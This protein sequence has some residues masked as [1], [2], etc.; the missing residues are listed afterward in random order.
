MA[1]FKKNVG[2][3]R[4][5]DLI[6]SPAK[7]I[8]VASGSRCFAK[9]TLVQ[10]IS[11]HK[12]INEI[13]I[14]ELVLSTNNLT[15]EFE[16]KKVLET[17][18]NGTD[19]TKHMLI[20]VLN[21]GVQ[22]EC[23]KEHELR[24]KNNFIPASTIAERAMENGEWNKRK[25]SSKQFGKTE[26]YELEVFRKT[27]SDEARS[28]RKRIFENYDSEGGREIPYDKDASNSCINLDRQSNEQGRGKSHQQRSKGQQS[29]E[30]RMGYSSGK[31]ETHD[32]SRKT[33]IQQWIKEWNVNNDRGTSI[34]NKGRIQQGERVDDQ[35]MVGAF[36]S[37]VFCS[38]RP[39]IR[40]NLEAREINLDEI[41]EI[42]FYIA[43]VETFDLC[44]EDNH[45]YTVTEENIIVHNSG[46]TFII[47]YAI[48]FIATK[49]PGSRHLIARKHFN[50]VK[51]SI[52]LDTLPK[53][54]DICFPEL[55]PFIKWNNTDFYIEL[56]N[57][58]QLWFAG[59]DDKE[60]VDKILGR[61]YMTIFFNECS[62]ITYDTYNTVKSR[63]AQQCSYVNEK[64]DL[65]MGKNMCL[66]D[67]NPTTSRH[68]TK[69]LFLDK[70]DPMSE[71][72]PKQPVRNPDRYAFTYIHPHENQENISKDYIEM[73][74]SLPP[75]QRKRFLDGI[76]ADS[77]AFAL[78]D[79]DIINKHRVTVAPPLKR[80]VVSV[81]P[82]VTSHDESDE[83]GI[84]V[85]G[86]G[87]DN[88]LYPLDDRTGK[89]TPNEWA[90]AAVRAYDDWNADRIVAE[91]NQGGDM[92]ETLVRSVRGNIPYTAVRATRDKR[93][94][95]E[96]VSALYYQGKC[97]HVGVLTQLE[98]QMTQWEGKKGDASPNNI[99]ALVWA[100]ADLFPELNVNQRMQG[101][102][103][104]AMR[105]M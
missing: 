7:E 102:F 24:F 40:K 49:F 29:R 90:E 61:E 98:Y 39:P 33:D 72:S 64:G 10:T 104:A 100:A 47:I 103:A 6:K 58:A 93:T 85:A 50:H 2:Q 4:V 48:L 57:G 9:G 53:V 62:E 86:I 27:S 46:K 25:V 52:W 81:D 14:G 15:G 1:I 41:V 74:E 66:L 96:P 38:S 87:W 21:N 13:E 77:S 19:K 59:L 94:R 5:L 76:Y 69:I 80:I 92:V 99:D 101:N 28:G 55:K 56:P 23:T 22:I 45:N 8:L 36:R 3:Q 17:F 42:Y 79:D 75:A 68:W 18:R 20:F 91:V 88:H 54:I 78:W 95:A 16:Y 11:G 63:L 26:D 83:T 60:R 71:T 32:G 12:P 35:T 105:G 34:T 84:I 89:Y 97:H 31:S 44:V 43:E 30:L 51:G 37:K 82:A 67:C 65:V 70:L 73:L